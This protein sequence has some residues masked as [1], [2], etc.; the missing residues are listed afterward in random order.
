MLASPEIGLQGCERK[1]VW[2]RDGHG[3]ATLCSSSLLFCSRTSTLSSHA[4]LHQLHRV[5]IPHTC[6]GLEDPSEWFPLRRAI[7]SPSPLRS[8][9]IGSRCGATA[10]SCDSSNAIA[11][12]VLLSHLLHISSVSLRNILHTSCHFSSASTHLSCSFVRA[13]KLAVGEGG[14]VI[15]GSMAPISDTSC[16]ATLLMSDDYLPGAMVMGWSLR[17]N[18]AATRKIVAL[19][20]VDTVSASTITELKVCPQAHSF[21]NQN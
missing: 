13:L 4:L 19:V 12:A 18:G 21:E 5:V 9:C 15:T 6:G 1:G 20:T 10:E 11:I 17:N 7:S 8:S 14:A 2:Q 3:R 16:Y